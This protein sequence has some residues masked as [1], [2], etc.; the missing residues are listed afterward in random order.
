MRPLRVK[1][2]SRAHPFALDLAARVREAL[3]SL[4]DV[5]VEVADRRVLLSGDTEQSLERAIAAASACVPDLAADKLCVLESP[6]RTPYYRLELLVPDEY[7]GEVL[8]E[9]HMRGARLEAPTAVDAGIRVCAKIPL[10]SALGCADT[11]MLMTRGQAELTC[12][13][14]GYEA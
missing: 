4:T 10:A 1:V 12:T 8:A 14:I 5:D 13:F 7:I 11:L 2:A 3:R 6:G 9:L